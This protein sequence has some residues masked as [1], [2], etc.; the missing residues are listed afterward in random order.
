MVRDAAELICPSETIRS[1][2]LRRRPTAATS[3]I[4]NGLDPDRFRPAGHG[5]PILAVNKR[6]ERKG[7][8]YL[9]RALEGMPLEHA[10][11][12]VGDG[13]YLPVLEELRHARSC[14]AGRG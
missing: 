10:V 11:Q 5:T 6:F 14:A 7:I 4:P 8:R 13:T 3:I 2:V 9:L 1:L 12:I